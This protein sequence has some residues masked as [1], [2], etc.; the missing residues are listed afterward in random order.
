M[1]LITGGLGYL[2]SRITKDLISRGESVRIATSRLE[3]L[4]NDL[5]S[6]DSSES[7]EITH[8]DLNDINSINRA[9]R[10]IQS[11]IHLAAMDASSSAENPN[12]ALKINAGGTLNLLNTAKRQN[13]RNFIYLSTVHVYGY[14]LEG[15]LTEEKIPQPIHHYS[16]SHRVAE[17]YV[18]QSHSLGDLKGLVFRLTNAVG[19]PSKKSCSSW[20]L[21]VNDLCKQIVISN[22][23][24]IHSCPNTQRDFV[25]ISDVCSVLY[26]S[27]MNNEVFGKIYNLS[28]GSCHTLKNIAEIIKDRA[29]N[30]LGVKPDIEFVETESNDNINL[31]V[32][33]K[34]ILDA[35]FKLKLDISSEIDKL[36]S[37]SNK[38]FGK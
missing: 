27:L 24:L 8:L 34:K 18:L 14:P 38:W 30:V 19:S 2:G 12:E 20:K 1:I 28:S 11:I 15:T 10:G 4:N 37:N 17:D 35:G 7:Y 3:A 6:D 29:S 36:L 21:V 5:G 13:V 9:C 16:I 22:K 26:E 25:P 32:S 23:M 31:V 33:N